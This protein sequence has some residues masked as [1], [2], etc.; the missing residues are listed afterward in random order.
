[1][2]RICFG[3]L[4]SI[5]SFSF[6]QTDI[7][8]VTNVDINSEY[9]HFGLMYSSANEII[10]SSFLLND[11]GRVQKSQG[12]EI[13]T[14]FKGTVSSSG[15]I[16]VYAPIQIDSSYKLD[17]ITSASISPDGKYLY[18]TTQYISKDMS[19]GNFKQDNFHIKRGVFKAGVGW[20]DFVVL[21]FCN[22]KYSYAHPALSPD[23]KVLYFT[24]NIRGGKETTRGGSDIFTVEVLDDGSYGE[25]KNLGSM[26]NSY[27][28][29]MFPFVDL[30]GTLY[31]AS[32]HP[33]GYGGY[34]IYRCR[35]G[36]D[37]NFERAEKLPK[38]IN[39]RSDDLSFVINLV[40][41]SGYV[42]SKREGGKGDD[43]IY[44]FKPI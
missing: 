6:A 32:N 40:T 2:F 28:K 19:K 18:V 26:V 21:P 13:L 8:T 25:P 10:F 35:L 36:A 4:F 14:V 44:Y 33:N 16:D 38:P 1:M 42:S 23:G 43:D 29:E 3:F 9:P 11:K 31:L 27:S 12:R 22:P 15:G 41:N 30:E 7:F 24:S 34:D 39:S 37:G 17:Y 20:T 5:A